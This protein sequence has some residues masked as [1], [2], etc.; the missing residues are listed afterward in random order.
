MKKA[1]R[2][3]IGARKRLGPAPTTSS[4]HQP[5]TAHNA[6]SPR[7][8]HPSP[9]TPEAAAAR[10]TP[11]PHRHHHPPSGPS[12]DHAKTTTDRGGGRRASKQARRQASGRASRTRLAA[13]GGRR[14]A[15]GGRRSARRHADEAAA[16]QAVPANRT[17]CRAAQAAGGRQSAAWRP[18]AGGYGCACSSVDVW[19]LGLG[20]TLET[21][22]GRL[23]AKHRPQPLRSGAPGP[24][25][26]R[27]LAAPRGWEPWAAAG[28]GERNRQDLRLRALRRAA[29][30]VNVAYTERRGTWSSTAG[31]RHGA[32]GPPASPHPRRARAI[33]TKMQKDAHLPQH[34]NRPPRQVLGARAGTVG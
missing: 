15:V 11:N 10:T 34:K 6:A 2:K 24:G 4:R 33:S 1:L 3:R 21:A 18:A 31:A 12:R 28:S 14:S 7:A 27:P 29:R 17:R 19:V 16:G 26:R 23:S 5:R 25:G 30:Y 22:V 9:T 8:R 13:H 32:A 20:G